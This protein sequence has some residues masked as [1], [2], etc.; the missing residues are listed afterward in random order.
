MI[1]CF[2]VQILRLCVIETE[3]EEFYD[4]IATGVLCLGNLDDN[5]CQLND[6]FFNVGLLFF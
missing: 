2:I 1:Y 4:R 3:M 5:I 6:F